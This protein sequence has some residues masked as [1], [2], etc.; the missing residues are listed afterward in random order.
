MIT[1]RKFVEQGEAAPVM[2]AVPTPAP[3][4]TGD[5]DTH[6]DSRAFDVEFDIS[7][8]DRKI[9]DESDAFLML[10]P[11]LIEKHGLEAAGPMTAQILKKYPNGSAKVKILY[12]SGGINK[13]KLQ[14]FHGN[15]YKGIIEDKVIYLSKDDIEDAKADALQQM[16]SPAPDMSGG[17]M[18]GGMGMDMGGGM[19]AAPPM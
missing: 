17:M 15:A 14:N 9:A 12:K 6:N 13:Q 3:S 1:F 5:K 4:P 8:E 19:G 10:N 16:V 18:G 11:R 7:P 2:G